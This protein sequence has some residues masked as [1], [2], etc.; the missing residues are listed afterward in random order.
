MSCG[1]LGEGFQPPPYS[2][3]IPATGLLLAKA[4]PGEN[5]TRQGVDGEILAEGAERPPGCKQSA[6]A[7]ACSNDV[8]PQRSR[9][10][11]HRVESPSGNVPSDPQRFGGEKH[12]AGTRRSASA[13]SNPCPSHGVDRRTLSNRATTCSGCE[14]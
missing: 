12:F 9:T 14:T 3:E 7:I 4:A 11:D 5:V 2:G 1:A 6:R 8:A 13:E 10:H